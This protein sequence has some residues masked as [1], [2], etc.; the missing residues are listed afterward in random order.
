MVTEQPDQVLLPIETGG[1]QKFL[2]G[3]VNPF[4]THRASRNDTTIQPTIV[5]SNQETGEEKV[6]GT[7]LPSGV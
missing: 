1:S 5:H 6:I 3:F 2:V 7:N 4:S